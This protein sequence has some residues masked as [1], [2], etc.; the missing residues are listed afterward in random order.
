MQSLGAYGKRQVRLD[1]CWAKMFFWAIEACQTCSGLRPQD[2]KSWNESQDIGQLKIQAY[3]CNRNG[4]A[5]RNGNID[6]QG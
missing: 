6:D 2:T 3:Q 5:S 4:N 1:Q